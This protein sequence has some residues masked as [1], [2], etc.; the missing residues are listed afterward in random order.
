MLATDR[1]AAAVRE[2]ERTA[3]ALGITAVPFFVVDRRVGVAGAQ[4]A[5][6]LGELLRQAWADRPAVPVAAAGDACAVDG[7]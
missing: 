2:D 3:A 6:V 5:A 4:P 1:F 7:C